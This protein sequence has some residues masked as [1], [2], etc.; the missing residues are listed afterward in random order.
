MA[1]EDAEALGGGG[2]EASPLSIGAE[3]EEEVEEAAKPKSFESKSSLQQQ[4]SS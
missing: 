4:V 2:I 3:G 1:V